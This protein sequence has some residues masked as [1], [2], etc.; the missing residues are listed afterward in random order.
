MRRPSAKMQRLAK[1]AGIPLSIVPVDTQLI[2]H[3]PTTARLPIYMY[4]RLLA[5]GVSLTNES[6][7]LWNYSADISKLNTRGAGLCRRNHG[8]GE[9][10][11]RT[12]SA[13]VTVQNDQQAEGVVLRDSH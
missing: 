13:G 10:P 2:A 9:I 6:D 8:R 12:R 4:L 3:L 11:I 1:H 5:P 7:V